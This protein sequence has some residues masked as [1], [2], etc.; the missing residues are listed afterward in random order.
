MANSSSN[1]PRAV[2]IL[3]ARALRRVGGRPND[4]LNTIAGLQRGHVSRRQ[5]LAA[6][7][8]SDTVA[9]WREQR[10]LK[11]IHRGVYRVG[12]AIE[13]P[14]AR[15]TAALLAFRPGAA[16]YGQSAL[17]LWEVAPAPERVHVVIAGHH[18]GRR[19]PGIAEHHSLTLTRRDIVIR[20]GLPTTTPARALLDYADG[21]ERRSLQ[22][23]LDEAL[24]RRIT[25][26]T[27]VIETVRRAGAGRRGARRLVELLDERNPVGVTRSEGERRLRELIEAADVPPPH[28]N[29]PLHGY[30]ADF[31][32]REARYVVEFDGAVAHMRMPAFTRDRAKDRR[33]QDHGI[34]VDRFT[35]A[36]ITQR[37]IETATHIAVTV[38]RRTTAA[39]AA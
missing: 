9:Y 2:W 35:W 11:L 10:L 12:P 21:A 7:V 19:R 4:V 28:R 6:G 15:E 16:L 27:K 1:C 33:L 20:S 18:T 8:P 3:G 36:D 29:D 17:A 13:V 24:Y 22:D 32:W 39:E 23:A 34:R 37:P 31:H 25:S 30:V 5:L 14:L 26:R 38:A